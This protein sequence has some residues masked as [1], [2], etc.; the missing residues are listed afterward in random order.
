MNSTASGN[1]FA[2]LL[3]A[4]WPLAAAVFVGLIA[5]S[6]TATIAL[7]ALLGVLAI[8]AGYFIGRRFVD[9]RGW[10]L[11]F[12][13]TLMLAAHAA[14]HTAH[15]P[16][17]YLQEVVIFG[18]GL[19]VAAQVWSR[20]HDDAALRAMVVIWL[21]YMAISMLSTALG[22]SRLLPALWQFQYNLKW[23]L[24]FGLG[25]L[26]IWGERPARWLDRIVGWG[27]LVL[28]GCVA[29]EIAAPGVH[30]KIF[31]PIVDYHSNPLIG[32][33]LRRRGPFSHS[34]Y[35]AIVAALLAATALARTI[36]GGSKL[37]LLPGGI[38]VALVLL[39][40]QRQE[41]LGLLLTFGLFAIIAWRRYWYLM[42]LAAVSLGAVALILILALGH[43]PMAQSLAQWGLVAS[44]EP[45]SERAILTYQGMAIA[46]QHFPLGSGLGTYG[47]PGAQKFDQRLYLELGF[48]RYWWFRQGLFLVDTFWPGVVAESG[49]FG[50]ALL[51]G[52]FFVAW[53]STLLRVLRA[54]HSPLHALGLS[55]LAALTLML[56]NSP[57]SGAMTDPRG[58]FL[59][60]MIVGTF[61]SASV[62]VPPARTGRI[63]TESSNAA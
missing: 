1:R 55:A 42:L 30:A 26:L 34:G 39:S 33:G 5:A 32:W 45:L 16:L 15:V 8:P 63:K 37:W 36:A 20:L 22:H 58:A 27:W 17:G 7:A 47:G 3:Y 54:E 4:G 29:M 19:G 46:D 43:V 23:P 52:L 31:G 51:L 40:G 24:M 10:L 11:P 56:A 21:A 18:L 25:Y 13:F 14:Q 61:W 28:L 59:F 12:G 49:Y 60:W 9:R 48:N 57:T 50:L 2:A 35:L 6:R 38:Y 62:P 44:Y 53:V 41:F